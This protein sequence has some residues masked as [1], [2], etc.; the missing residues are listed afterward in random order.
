MRFYGRTAELRTLHELLDS[1]QTKNTCRLAVVTGRRRIGK[2][3]LIEEAFRDC[4]VPYIYFF[5]SVGISE[6]DFCARLIKAVD[7]VN[8][9]LLVTADHGN[10]DEMYDKP[11]KEGAPIKSKTSHTLNRVPFIV[12]GADVTLK[13]DD[14]LGLSNIASTVADLLGVEPNEH[15]NESII[16]K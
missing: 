5:T 1:C 6:N 12:Y 16:E 3:T 8:G 7:K 11:K 10:A 14:S 15:W 13:Q 4:G 9:I 2:T